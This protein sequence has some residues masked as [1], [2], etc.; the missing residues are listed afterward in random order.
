MINLEQRERFWNLKN[1]ELE[2]KLKNLSRQGKRYR[3]GERV[4][5]SQKEANYEELR[6]IY[7]LAQEDIKEL[8][9]QLGK[10]KERANK[11]ETNIQVYK[12]RSKNHEK[13]NKSLTD[14][15][16]QKEAKILNTQMKFHSDDLGKA[17]EENK[18]MLNKVNNLES[19]LQETKANS[20]QKIK[21]SDLKILQIEEENFKIKESNKTLGKDLEIITRN[22]EK[23]KNQIEILLQRIKDLEY[24]LEIL[25]QK[26]FSPSPISSKKL[27]DLLEENQEILQAN[28]EIL[29]ENQ[30]ILQENAKLE[31]ENLNL[32]EQIEIYKEDHGR[33]SKENNLLQQLSFMI[34]SKDKSSIDSEVAKVLRNA[35]GD[36]PTRLIEAFQEKAYNFEQDNTILQQRVNQELQT[37]IEN[38]E[39]IKNLQE[40]LNKFIKEP[41]VES[42]ISRTKAQILA[43][44][45]ALS[46]SFLPRSPSGDLKTYGRDSELEMGKEIKAIKA[47]KEKLKEELYRNVDL[48]SNL[49]KKLH[50]YE[51]K[52]SESDI[53]CFIQCEAAALEDMLAESESPEL[54]SEELY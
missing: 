14:L 28:Q 3:S 52:P 36:N 21:N 7:E 22:Q 34:L 19:E 25:N 30:K 6:M 47:E 45:S 24:E 26:Q 16:N 53:I 48:I 46:S 8:K 42:E 4:K 23:Y 18:K 13:T 39:R 11:L 35:I 12:E 9:G 40:T 50:F 27:S 54:D 43:A 51:V 41:T 29:Q 20:Q 17:R 38:L 5:I 1:Q 15:L 44:K 33:K 10:E 32:K 31:S 2:E 37:R 49:E